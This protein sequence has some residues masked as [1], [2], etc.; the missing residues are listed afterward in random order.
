[1]FLRIAVLKNFAVLSRKHLCWSLFLIKLLVWRPAFL[2]KQRFQ[3]RC[4]PVKFLRRVFFIEHLLFIILFRNFMWWKNSLDV[5]GYKLDIF[6][7]ALIQAVF[8]VGGRFWGWQNW[9]PKNYK[10]IFFQDKFYS[11]KVL[12]TLLHFSHILSKWKSCQSWCFYLF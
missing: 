6:Q 4:F 11:V 8:H 10:T 7:P 5:F 9:S 12:C 2:L 3:H 1:M